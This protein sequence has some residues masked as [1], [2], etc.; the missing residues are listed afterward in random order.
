MR[1]P[2]V[3][4]SQLTLNELEV[5]V[6]RVLER[7]GYVVHRSDRPNYPDWDLTAYAHGGEELSVYIDQV[8]DHRVQGKCGLQE[9]VY[10][11]RVQLV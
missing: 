11:P 4:P 5:L 6:A 9:T 10:W 3:N 2:N 1:T 7:R 8:Y